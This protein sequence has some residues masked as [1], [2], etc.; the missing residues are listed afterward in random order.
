ML[1]IVEKLII[2]K[3]AQAWLASQDLVPLDWDELPVL[4]DPL[5]PV[6]AVTEEPRYSQI[7]FDAEIRSRIY[8]SR[9]DPDE[10]SNWAFVPGTEDR[11]WMVNIKRRSLHLN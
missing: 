10:T 2:S 11:V 4:P 7:P 5:I 1:T 3:N 8:R 9:Y 6:W